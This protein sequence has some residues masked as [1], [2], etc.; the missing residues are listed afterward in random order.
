MDS[1]SISEASGQ[2]EDL[3][4]R[5]QAGEE[6]TLTQ[7]GEPVARI[8]AV[9]PRPRSIDIAAMRALTESMAV[10]GN[11]AALLVRRMRDDARN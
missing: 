5:A 2:L 9:A 6:I 7:D 10:E 4:A 1:A 11:G 3:V 8:V